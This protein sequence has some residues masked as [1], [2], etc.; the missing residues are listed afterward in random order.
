MKG[1]LTA[2]GIALLVA[3]LYG[4]SWAITVGLIKLI[5][6]C[7]GLVFNLKIAT[8]IWLI[9]VFIQSLFKRSSKE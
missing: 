9:I 8:G 1:L 2:L 7:F 4:L 5:T 6:M 3:S